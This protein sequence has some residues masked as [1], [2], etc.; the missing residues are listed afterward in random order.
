VP[1]LDAVTS[2]AASPSS[3]T[4]PRVANE[5]VVIRGRFS[6]S[7][8]ITTSTRSP[9]NSTPVTD[10]TSTPATRTGAPSFKPATSGKTVLIE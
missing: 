6:F 5:V 10:P 2:T 1:A 3:D 8:S 9:T 7:T 4:D